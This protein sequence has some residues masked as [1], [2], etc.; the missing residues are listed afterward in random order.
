MARGPGFK[1]WR[2]LWQPGQGC[3]DLAVKRKSMA[4]SRYGSFVRQRE[5]ELSLD[6]ADTGWHAV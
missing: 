2:R 6:R 1:P 5:I 4:P 3:P